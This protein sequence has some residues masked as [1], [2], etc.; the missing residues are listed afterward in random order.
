MPSTHDRI[1]W[2][3]SAFEKPTSSFLECFYRG[4]L[5][6][7]RPGTEEERRAFDQLTAPENRQALKAWYARYPSINPGAEALHRILEK[8]IGER[9]PIGKP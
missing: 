8:A 5:S 3:F 2:L 1:M 9:L 7:W 4:D 6:T